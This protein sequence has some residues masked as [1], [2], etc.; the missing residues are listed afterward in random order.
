VT[1]TDA[2]PP[3]AELLTGEQVAARLG[4]S[5]QRVQQLTSRPD[6]PPPVGRIGKAVV[7]NMNDV[8][9]YARGVRKFFTVN[10]IS[11]GVDSAKQ[12]AARLH[13][14]AGGGVT[15]PA[16]DVSAEISRALESGDTGIT[17][18]DERAK[19]VFGAL[20]KWLEDTNVEVFPK[21]LSD[22]RYRLFADLQ[23]G[24]LFRR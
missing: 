19:A 5:R 18:V 16:A 14:Q 8:D 3:V 13:N 9:D 17:V 20:Q 15:G 22:L 21:P 24:G 11:I 10:R 6:F 4:I 12:L 2:I 23:D 7:Y 1:P